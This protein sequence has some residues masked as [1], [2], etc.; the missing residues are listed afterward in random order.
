MTQCSWFAS[1][2]LPF[3]VLFQFPTSSSCL[4][5]YSMLVLLL[6]VSEPAAL[7][8]G[9]CPVREKL[10]KSLQW[11]EIHFLFLPPFPLLA[12]KPALFTTLHFVFPFPTYFCF[13]SVP[14]FHSWRP[15]QDTIFI[16]F[17]SLSFY[18][19]ALSLLTS[20]ILILL[21]S[22]QLFLCA[23]VCVTLSHCGVFSLL[24]FHLA[25]KPAL[26]SHGWTH[27]H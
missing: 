27:R 23:C 25:S 18:F 9:A 6:S 7:S 22:M 2:S 24:V 26:P 8:R 20:I 10:K 11:W 21:P 14:F 16:Y 4:S 17:L 19:P 3:F 12:F 13:F 15:H 5:V 1:L